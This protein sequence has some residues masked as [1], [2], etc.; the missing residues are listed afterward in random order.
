M[1]MGKK[2]KRN[3]DYWDIDP[4]S[5]I[6]KMEEYTPISTPI[7]TSEEMGSPDCQ[8]NHI[9]S[10][11]A[12]IP[13]QYPKKDEDKH[14]VSLYAVKSMKQIMEFPSCSNGDIFLMNTD[15]P[16]IYMVTDHTRIHSG[17]GLVLFSQYVEPVARVSTKYDTWI[18]YNRE[19]DTIR[20]YD[21][22]NEYV[23]DF[24]KMPD[25]GI[26]KRAI[27]LS[28]FS[29]YAN[30]LIMYI[31][32]NTVPFTILDLDEAETLLRPY[33]RGTQLHMNPNF[34]VMVSGSKLYFY[35]MEQSILEIL[36]LLKRKYKA[37]SIT[38]DII[39]SLV[40]MAKTIE[41]HKVFFELPLPESEVVKTI[42]TEERKN[43]LLEY[44]ETAKM[45]AVDEEIPILS[46]L[47]ALH[48]DHIYMSASGI[49]SALLDN[50]EGDEYVEY[51]EDDSI[52]D[53]FSDVSEKE[54]AKSDDS[55]KFIIPTVRKNGR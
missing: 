25:Y 38:Y 52:E 48:F 53:L 49:I 27:D 18:H 42:C 3:R 5:Q 45:D 51:G 22:I 11:P 10:T 15:P 35:K 20:I 23:F 41:E 9:Y 16:S 2:K 1:V 4:I 7:Y 31:L 24:T 29:E 32:I 37:K 44:F 13:P 39:A 14:K 36:E 12:P 54:E 30:N 21:S 28:A 6:K 46:A 8:G 34:M 40:F 43:L 55:E 19:K 47:K 26:Q 33:L 17:D 50:H